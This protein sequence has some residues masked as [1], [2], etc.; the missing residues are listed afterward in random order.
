MRFDV[1][2]AKPQGYGR[3]RWLPPNGS[4]HLP[5][6]Q[7]FM[8]RLAPVAHGEK[9]PLK[10]QKFDFWRGF[11][12]GFCKTGDSTKFDVMP[13]AIYLRF[14]KRGTMLHI[15]YSRQGLQKSDFCASRP[16]LSP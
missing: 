11:R 15:S 14:F 9:V 4:P 12:G 7:R 16:V 6:P 10:A 1:V 3:E 5:A 13:H 8:L 2:C